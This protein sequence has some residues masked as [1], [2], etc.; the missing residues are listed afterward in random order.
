LL[1]E[2]KAGTAPTDE[3]W[4][5]AFRRNRLNRGDQPAAPYFLVVTTDRTFLWTQHWQQS[6]DAPPDVNVSTEVLLA[7]YRSGAGSTMAEVSISIHNFEFVVWSWLRDVVD[8]QDLR[9]G[10]DMT[11][12]REAGLF[13]AL[14]GGAIEVLGHRR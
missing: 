10:L 13:D 8:G 7:P 9:A 11:C 4:G 1:V 14:R 3:S 2:V 5:V 6:P 12:L